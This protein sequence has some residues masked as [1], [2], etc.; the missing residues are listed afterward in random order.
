MSNQCKK[1]HFDYAGIARE[2][3]FDVINDLLTHPSIF[4]HSTDIGCEKPE[5]FK[6][7]LT[8][9]REYYVASTHE[10]PY[11]GIFGV[12]NLTATTV[13]LHVG[14]LPCA[15]GYVAKMALI[16]LLEM[17]AKQGVITAVA[18]IAPSNSAVKRYA[19]FIGFK[20]TGI[21]PNAIVINRQLEDLLVFT[22]RL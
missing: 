15:R 2:H 12:D 21:I 7:D 4:Y 9:R 13:I 22:R 16:D 17:L 19:Q 3:R 10:H 5:Y 1:T 20:Q 14:F 18:Y 6:L 11:C 8:L